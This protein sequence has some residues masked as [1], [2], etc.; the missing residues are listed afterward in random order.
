MK[1]IL[2]QVMSQTIPIAQDEWEA[3]EPHIFTKTI[4]KREQLI[5]L[6]QTCTEIAVVIK[7][8]FRQYHIIDG[9]EKTT[10]FYFDNQFVCNYESI[11]L[12][13][14]SNIVIEA[15]EDCE[16]LYFKNE[17]MQRLYRLYPKYEVFGR[18][19]AEN[20]YLCAMER[21]NTF[22]LNSPEG[23]YRKFL[24]HHDSQQILNRVPQHYIASYLGITPVS[25]SRIRAR[26]ARQAREL[27]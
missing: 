24:E 1:E 5:R 23:R 3:F 21:L 13:T 25:L 4:K 20:V 27:A 10:F 9:E 2:R 15:M 14:P 22:L 18:L 19:I 8:S 26:V 17:T 12:Q 16:L 6:G 11:L 7:G